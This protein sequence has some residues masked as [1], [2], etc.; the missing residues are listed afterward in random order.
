MTWD[1]RASADF[2]ATV[3][4]FKDVYPEKEYL[5]IIKTIREAIAEL[6]ETGRVSEAG[7]NEH[8]LAKS[9]FDDG[10][11]F[12]FH[13]H[14]DDVLVVYFKRERRRVIRMVGVYSHRSIPSA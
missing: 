5:A 11:H 14:D 12:E 3:R 9:P 6:A 8:R 2:W 13:I 1:V 4:P 7:W 10:N